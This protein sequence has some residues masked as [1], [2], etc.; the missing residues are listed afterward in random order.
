MI[1]DKLALVFLSGVRIIVASKYIYEKL[2]DELTKK[3]ILN[4]SSDGY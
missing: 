2:G 4:A 1:A 3:E